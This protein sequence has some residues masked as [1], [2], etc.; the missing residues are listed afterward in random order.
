M[1]DAGRYNL[2]DQ[3]SG[4]LQLPQPKFGCCASIVTYLRAWRAGC[5]V[6]EAPQLVLHALSLKHQ[7][8][9]FLANVAIAFA[10]SRILM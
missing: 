9:F 6:V 10:L 2:C 4:G 5:I 8:K 1:C 3:V 7:Q